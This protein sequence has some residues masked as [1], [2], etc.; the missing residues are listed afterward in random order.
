[1][2]VVCIFLFFFKIQCEF[3]VYFME[4]SICFFFSMDFSVYFICN[5]GCKESSNLPKFMWNVFKCTAFSAT[6]GR[7][8]ELFCFLHGV[9]KS[10]RI[11][12]AGM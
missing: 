4:F 2:F 9:Y 11:W 8:K 3:S 6:Q 1:M 12:K 7:E 5:L 10:N